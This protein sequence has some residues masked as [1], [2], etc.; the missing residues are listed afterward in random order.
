[1]EIEKMKMKKLQIIRR[2]IKTQKLIYADVSF[3]KRKF[4]LQND[5][6]DEFPKQQNTMKNLYDLDLLNL[7]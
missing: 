2:M 3:K 7:K 1:M 4:V 5:D 6:M